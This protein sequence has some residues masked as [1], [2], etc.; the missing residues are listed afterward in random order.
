MK[1]HYT[2]V[3]LYTQRNNELKYILELTTNSGHANE[4]YEF[5]NKEQAMNAREKA[6]WIH[7]HQYCKQD[8]ES[9]ETMSKLET[10]FIRTGL[11]AM[12]QAKNFYKWCMR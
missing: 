5:D 11:T 12:K 4:Y 7:T 3:K 1:K 10:A 6:I 2:E 9:F 8:F